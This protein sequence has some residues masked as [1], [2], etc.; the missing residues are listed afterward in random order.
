MRAQFDPCRT[1]LGRIR[2][3]KS[4]L[5]SFSSG[6]AFPEALCYTC[7]DVA[8]VCSSSYL[9]THSEIATHSTAFSLPEDS[10]S[11]TSLSLTESLKDVIPVGTV[12]C[13]INTKLYC[14]AELMTTRF[15]NWLKVF[16]VSFV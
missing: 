7:K 14:S 12:A 10:N 2:C 8:F 13:D 9:E 6:E 5:K 11:D 1:R 4:C 15:G 3:L 16:E